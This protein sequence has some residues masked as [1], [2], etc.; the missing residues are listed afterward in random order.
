MRYTVLSYGCRS[1]SPERAA[2]RP[3]RESEGPRDRG[4]RA[5]VARARRLVEVD[6]VMARSYGS[7]AVGT[8]RRVTGPKKGE[9]MRC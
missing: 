2:A 7:P 9:V 4:S 8:M 3:R 5:I 1:S 6:V